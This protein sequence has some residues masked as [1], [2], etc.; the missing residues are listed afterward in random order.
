MCRH[1]CRVE[2]ITGV[3]SRFSKFWNG[4]ISELTIKLNSVTCIFTVCPLLPVLFSVIDL[5]VFKVNRAVPYFISD[6][7]CFGNA[8]GQWLNDQ[9]CKS[10]ENVSKEYNLLI[11]VAFHLSF[12]ES[13]EKAIRTVTAKTVALFFHVFGRAIMNVS[14]MM[15]HSSIDA[16]PSIQMHC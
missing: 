10:Q 5:I 2:L 4:L 15:R 6:A 16:H 3:H 7:G 9:H 12:C 11:I 1:T 8:Y 13:Y 14:P